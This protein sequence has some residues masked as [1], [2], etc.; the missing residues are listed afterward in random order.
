MNEHID[1]TA[2][3]IKMVNQIAAN[4][5]AYPPAEAAD[6]IAQHLTRFW[7]PK[8]RQDLIKTVSNESDISP[9]ARHAINILQANESSK[10]PSHPV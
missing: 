6:R 8:M 4:L 9:L 7:A 2:T 3:L 5:S 1:Q 10:Q